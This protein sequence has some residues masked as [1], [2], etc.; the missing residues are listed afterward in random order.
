MEGD[1][2]EGG[3]SGGGW[4]GSDACWLDADGRIGM[5]NQA[6]QRE[7]GVFFFIQAVVCGSRGRKGQGCVLLHSSRVIYLIVFHP[8]AHSPAGAATA[9]KVWRSVKP[10]NLASSQLGVCYL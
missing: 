8:L 5:V 7:E 9:Q 2:E 10:R 4:G 6:Q 3:D 1:Q